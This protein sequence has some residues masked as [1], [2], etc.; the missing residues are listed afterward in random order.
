M[1]SCVPLQVPH[2]GSEAF[3]AF[4]AASREC[5]PPAGTMTERRGGKEG[6]IEFCQNSGKEAI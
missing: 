6:Q 2:P 3:L 4:F 1:D 5:I